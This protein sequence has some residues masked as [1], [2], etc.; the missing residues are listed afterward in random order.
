MDE[1]GC[2]GNCAEWCGN[3]ESEEPMAC[4]RE[5]G[6]MRISP[7][8][9]PIEMEPTGVYLSDHECHRPKDWKPKEQA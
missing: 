9:L 5:L 2:C 7:E 4:C 6:S 1:N 8:G 3:D